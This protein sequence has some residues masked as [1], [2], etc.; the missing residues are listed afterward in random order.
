MTFLN[1]NLYFRQN[2][3]MKKLFCFLLPFLLLSCTDNN[4]DDF[5]SD[6]NLLILPDSFNY[7]FLSEAN[8]W[9]MDYGLIKIKYS[10]NNLP[11]Q[12]LGDFVSLPSGHRISSVFDS[13][14]YEEYQYNGNKVLRLKKNTIDSYV[15]NFR[16]EFVVENNKIISSKEYHISKI[17]G[18]DTRTKYFYQNDRLS[19]KIIYWTDSSNN[20]YSDY[21]IESIYY[22]NAK[23]NLDSIISQ[24]VVLDANLN[25]NYDFDRFKTKQVKILKNYDNSKN[26][27]KQL[28]LLDRFFDRSLSVNNYRHVIE[29]SY[30]DGVLSRHNEFDILYF[31]ENNEIDLTR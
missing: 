29:K 19:K 22:F 10:E 18:L 13:T 11:I 30:Y 27:F 28:Y 17:E 8:I 25:T 26:P 12:V 5:N 1:K 2:K 16:A 31:Y 23:N 14:R 7:R 9:P 6:E 4:D 21:G 20:N 3:S 24:N 15:S